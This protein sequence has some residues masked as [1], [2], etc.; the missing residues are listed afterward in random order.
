M[1]SYELKQLVSKIFGD[2]ETR[3]EFIKDPN[4]VMARFSLTEP[5]K[6]AVLSTHAKLGLVAGNSVQL[7]ETLG[8][9]AM[10]L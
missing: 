7:E 9:T 5:E 3:E 1:E 6:K 4:S 2:Q 10:W 8:P